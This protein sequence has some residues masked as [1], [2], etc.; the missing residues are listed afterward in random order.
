MFVPPND[1]AR[2]LDTLPNGKT[3]TLI[4]NDYV[5]AFRERR[6]D[7]RDSRECLGIHDASRGTQEG[8]YIGLGL[9]VDILGTVESTRAAGTNAIVPQGLNSL[10]LQGLIRVE[11]IEIIGAEV[12]HRATICKLGLGTDRTAK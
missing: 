11:I 6:D 2:D 9:Q 7:T 12:C 1:T 3:D 8:R 10:L 4:R 5:T